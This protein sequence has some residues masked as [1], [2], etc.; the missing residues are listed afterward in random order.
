MKVQ[1]LCLLRNG[2]QV[3]LG[4]KKR[5]FGTGKWNGFGGKLHVGET[6]EKALIREMN[7]E[8]GITAR[9]EDLDKVGKLRFKFKDGTKIQVHVFTLAKWEGEPAESEEMAPKWHHV[10][11]IPYHAMWPDDK[12]WLPL[13]LAGKKV[14][15]TFHF[16]EDASD[17]EHMEV[18]EV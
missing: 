16:T 2:E 11:E 13:V 12:H 18:R 8:I 9:Q 3:L 10:S 4:M 7:E 5:R 17:F 1:T 15:G 14:E 6:I